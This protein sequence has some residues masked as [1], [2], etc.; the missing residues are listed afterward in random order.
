MRN[1]G[2]CAFIIKPLTVRV[3]LVLLVV[4]SVKLH[5]TAYN[6]KSQFHNKDL[7]TMHKPESFAEGSC[8][9]IF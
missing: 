5:L 2:T 7:S 6:Q 3:K 9:Q 8:Q 1:S 4:Y